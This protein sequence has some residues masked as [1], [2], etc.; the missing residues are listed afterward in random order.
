MAR[1]FILLTIVMLAASGPSLESETGAKSTNDGD[2]LTAETFS[3]LAFRSLGPALMSGR[4]ADIA[5]HPHR[6]HEYYVAAASGGVWKTMDAG[7]TWAPIFDQEDSYSIGCLAIDPE[8][9][10]VLWV[11]TGE[12]NSQR[13]VSYGDGIYKSTDGGASWNRVGLEHSEHIAKILIDP[14]DSDTVYVAAQG[15][16]WGPGGDRGLYKTTDGGAS[17]NA[18]L[19]ISENTGVTDVVM[20][21]RN[22]DVLYAAAY[23]RRRRAW[24]LI[25]G[26]PES[27]I[28]KSVDGGKTWTK[29]E[30]GLPEEDMGRIGLAIAPTRPD[31]VYAIIEAAGKAGGFYRSSNGGGTWIKR[32]DYISSSPQYY[33]EIVPDP[34]DAD[35]VYSLDTFM[36]VTEDGGK[37]FHKVGGRTKHVD[38]HALW[39]DPADPAY[40]L[41]GCDGGLY[42]SFSRGL[43]WG[44]KAN[45]PVTQFYRVGLDNDFPFYNLYGGTQDNATLGGPSR[46][47]S[48]HGITNR[49]WFVTVFG[50][51]FGTQ[52]DPEDPDTIYSQ[53]QYG[54]LVRFNRRSG[55]ITDIQPQP[56]PGEPALRWNWNSPLMI[57]PH[58]H[59]RLYFG[60][61]ALFRSD[62][63]GN[64]W[65]A[66]SG[67]L[68]RGLERNQLEV[69]GRIQ[70]VD[71]VAK[72]ESTSFFGNLVALSESPL[73]EGLLYAGTDDGLIQVSGDGGRSWRR[74]ARFPGVPEMASVSDIEA[75]LHEPDTVYVTFDNHKSADFKPYVLKSAD[76]G[77]RWTS[78]SGDLPGRGSVHSLKEDHVHPGLL[79]AGTEFGVYFTQ[80]GGRR[81]IQLEG[82]LPTIA[83]RDLE[84]QRRENDLIIATFGRGFY[85]LDDYTPL[86]ILNEDMLARDAVLL[87][88]KNPWLYVPSH[89]LGLPGKSFQGDAFY[90]AP[91]PPF[92]ATITYYLRETIKTR[93]QRRRDF[94]K[95]RLEAHETSPYP[96]WDD[97]RL[98][99]REEKPAVVLTVK[100]G[101]GRILRRLTGPVTSGL[102]RVAWDLRLP[103]PNPTRLKPPEDLP[104]WAAP[105]RGPLVVPGPYAVDLATRVDGKTLSLAA[106]QDF[107]VIPLGAGTMDAAQRR[108]L[109]EFERRTARLQRAVLGAVRTLADAQVRLD[110]IK[111]ALYDTPEIDPSM[112]SRVRSLERRLKTLRAELAGD[113][114][115][116]ERN[117]PVP[118][119]LVGRVQRIVEGHWSST[120]A[121]TT[122]QRQNYDAAAAA[123]GSLLEK[124]RELVKEDMGRLETDLETARVP[125][126]PGRVPLWQ[127]D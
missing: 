18:V 14:R 56:G 98:E 118:P 94:E 80:D 24:T 28:H 62:D 8:D 2:L 123:F 108:D 12:N 34:L 101:Q 89:A 120:S 55:E 107:S 100:D 11:G 53:S 26:G 21:P 119:S 58:S 91:N 4:I 29:L 90:S 45:L 37:K 30:Q 5:V 109:Y 47:I 87:P 82:G 19:Q 3:G 115:L 71:A 22:P 41:A 102:H 50:D 99:D 27:A 32:S 113:R 67:D 65:H 75:S 117:E 124:I 83:V 70:S 97:L 92:G 93:Q 106:S 77:H 121:P 17:W 73:L 74:I 63:R 44:F 35:R 88:V 81:W 33:Q 49:D 10:L 42:E 36:M 57:S 38:D 103:A 1:L 54:G 95:E 31:T 39:I 52:V 111:Q 66:V 59:T 48:S 25:D 126:T 9:P 64:T 122:T 51:G 79:F 112:D 13:S 69:M 76:R 60:A 43:T 46:T 105:P 68:T 85:I 7:I 40:L 114:T 125:W 15:P 104:P 6:R 116:Q 20:D 86:R 127:P 23:Q 78:V 96:T 16:L 84:I 72:N 110:H 61:Q